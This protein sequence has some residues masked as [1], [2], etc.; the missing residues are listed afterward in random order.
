MPKNEAYYE[1]GKYST[2]KYYALHKDHIKEIGERRWTCECG[3]ECRRDKKAQHTRSVKHKKTMA[4]INELVEA[5]LERRIAKAV[6]DVE[7]SEEL[8]EQSEGSETVDGRDHD[9]E[10]SED[11]CFS[12]LE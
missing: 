2:K 6:E 5:E 8:I 10:C 7:E 3:A 11:V 1:N 12:D 9:D 4:R